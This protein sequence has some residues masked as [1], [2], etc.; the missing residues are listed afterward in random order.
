MKNHPQVHNGGRVKFDD[1]EGTIRQIY[2][3]GICVIVFDGGQIVAVP[4]N[5]VEAIDK[6]SNDKPSNDKPP[7]DKR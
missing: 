5:Q 7:H 1:R 6:P 3:D 2:P 4:V